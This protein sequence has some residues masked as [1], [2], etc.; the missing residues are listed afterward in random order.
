M[1]QIG[2]RYPVYA[3]LVEDEAAGTY[4]YD[5][6]KV[7]AKAISVEMSLNIA[8]APLYADDGI[9]ERVRE[10]ID[11]TL[12]F[13]PDDLSDEVKAE[14]LGSEIE[15]ETI[16]EETTVSVLKRHRICPAISVSVSSPKVKKM[17][18]SGYHLTKVQFAEPN[19]SP[20]QG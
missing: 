3:P 1:A 17:S 20:D 19:E 14:W 9:A 15:E 5:T 13:T 10:F 7:A 4:T 2:L 12:N 6:G 18:V 16:D 8:D 11:G